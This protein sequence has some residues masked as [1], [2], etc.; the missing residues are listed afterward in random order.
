MG[1]EL[2]LAPR[3][4]A[5]ME[6]MEK[7]AVSLGAP[8]APFPLSVSASHSTSRFVSPTGVGFWLHDVGSALHRTSQPGPLDC[9]GLPFCP[10][11]LSHPT[12]SSRG[13]SLK[14]E[15]SVE[16]RWKASDPVQAFLFIETR[17]APLQSHNP[18]EIFF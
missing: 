17:T 8:L 2:G 13:M 3:A 15:S 6:G 11:C 18:F 16:A 1:R 12:S 10:H 9:L 14:P 4:V 5:G 7:R